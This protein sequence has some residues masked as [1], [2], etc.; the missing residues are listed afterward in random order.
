[1]NRREA[2]A[3]MTALFGAN[4]IAPLAVAIEVGLDPV[5]LTGANVFSDTERRYLSELVDVIIPTTDTPGAK[6]AGVAQFIEFMLAEVY[7]Q[8]EQDAF[9]QNFRTLLRN[10]PLAAFLGMSAEERHALVASLQDGEMDAFEDGGVAFFTHL[11]QL[12]I[13]GYYSSEV[14]ITQERRFLPIP[15][16]Y[17]GAYPYAEVGTLFSS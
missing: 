4:L 1:M 15:G 9:E 12:T 7:G 11:K 2:L 16:R 14:G 3:G 5:D 8:D 6:D 17:D 10:L 13:A